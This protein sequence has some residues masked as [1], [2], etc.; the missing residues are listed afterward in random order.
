[1]KVRLRYFAALRE[2]LGRD[3]EER[4]VAAGATPRALLLEILGPPRAAHAAS[5]AFAVNSEHAAPDR[6]LRDGDEVAFLPPLSGG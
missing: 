2:L 4:E 1:V 3:R 6:P 5:V